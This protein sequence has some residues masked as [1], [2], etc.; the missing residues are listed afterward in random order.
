MKFFSDCSG[1]CKDCVLHYLN[2]C[3]AGH[4]DDDF[5]QVTEKDIPHI[6]RYSD[7]NTIKRL[8]DNYPD[9]ERIIKLKQINNKYN[10]NKKDKN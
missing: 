6:L 8:C 5:T 10:D 7:E 2:G 9:F 4:G 1:E 3:L